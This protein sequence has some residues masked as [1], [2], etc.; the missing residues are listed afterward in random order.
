MTAVLNN[1][2]QSGLDQQTLAPIRYT[3]PE[4]SSEGSQSVINPPGTMNRLHRRSNIGLRCL[5]RRTSQIGLVL[6]LGLLA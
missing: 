3:R 1:S 4:S 2:Y 5:H 6:C